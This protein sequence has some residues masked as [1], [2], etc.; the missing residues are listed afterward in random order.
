MAPRPRILVAGLAP[1][2]RDVREALAADAETI[3]AESFQEA[4][5]R[6]EEE[7]PQAVVVAYHFDEIQPFRFIRCL[8]QDARFDS[9][10]LLLVRILPVNL[11]AT[12]AEVRQAYQDLG[13][14]EFFDLYERT[15][16]LG[17][18]AALDELRGCL[19]AMLGIG[20]DPTQ[21]RSPCARKC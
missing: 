15:R 8:R 4:Q 7:T 12:E 17:A 2:M 13:A 6:L 10:P 1:V 14:S 19:R 5:R 20:I 18:Q 11:G 16:R 3:S 9:V 21:R